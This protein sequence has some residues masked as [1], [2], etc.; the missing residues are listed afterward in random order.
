MSELVYVDDWSALHL[1]ANLC[2]GLFSG[3]KHYD[4]I[5]TIAVITAVGL[6]WEY[7]EHIYPESHETMK[8]HTTDMILNTLGFVAGYTLAT[9][10]KK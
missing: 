4:F 5:K 8:D 7:F 6:L 9:E 3:A 10:L 1:I 2:L